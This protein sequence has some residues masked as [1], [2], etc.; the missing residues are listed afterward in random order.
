MVIIVRRNDDM[1]R[2]EG[3][4]DGDI[5][6]VIDYDRRGD[7]LDITYTGTRIRFR[8]RGHASEVTRQAL[9]DIRAQGWKVHPICPFTVDYLDAHPEFADLRV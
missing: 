3:R 4:I 7:V 1:N 8:G 2:Y 9:E 6:T 5:V